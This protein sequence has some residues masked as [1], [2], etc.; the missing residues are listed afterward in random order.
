MKRAKKAIA[1]VS[2]AVLLVTGAIAGTLAYFTDTDAD[3]N[4]FTVG[5]VSIT[6]D[7]AKVNTDGTYVTDKNNRVTEN[8][9]HL[10]PGYTYIKDPTIHVDSNSEDCY[11]F[12]KVENAISAI[13]GENKIATQIAA[14][15]WK[16]VAITGLGENTKLYVYAE[17]SETK[18]IVEKTDTDRDRI[19]FNSFTIDG[20]KVVNVAKGETVPVDKF[21]IADYADKQ[22][23]VI[24]YAIQAAG[25]ENTN[26]ETIWTTA[27]FN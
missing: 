2:C 16:E 27:G 21:K 10:I 11:L 14:N 3:T 19:V 1:L 20:N 15:N 18:T 8:K 22:I 23:T 26:P 25:F 5:Q 13:E 4:T 24:A 12:V 9:Y 7:E 17:G 6:L